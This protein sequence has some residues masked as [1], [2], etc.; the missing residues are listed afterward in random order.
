MARRVVRTFRSRE[1]KSTN[2]VASTDI[3]GVSN[4]AAGATVLDQSFAPSSDVTVL[5]TRGSLWIKTDQVAADEIPFGAMGFCVVS[6]PALA[7]G[8]SALP[9]PQTDMQSDLWFV[10]E[11]ALQGFEFS[12]AA[13]FNFN[14]M[15][16]HDF[17]SKAMRKVNQ[18]QSI[19]VVLENGSST[20]GFSYLLQFR[21][22]LKDI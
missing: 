9:T 4:L 15:V 3:T 17:D 6:N 18:D 10:L 2:W 20:F 14:T 19:A 21:I 12:T 22:L 8:V 13:S 7:T 5:R 11:T 1:R 16:R